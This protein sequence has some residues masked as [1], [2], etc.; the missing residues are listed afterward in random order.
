MS[1]LFL[2]FFRCYFWREKMFFRNVKNC[3]VNMI[4]GK[5]EMFLRGY[6]CNN[7]RDASCRGMTRAVRTRQT[8][9]FFMIRNFPINKEGSGDDP[10]KSY[11][12]MNLPGRRLL[13]NIL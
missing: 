6:Y 3:K 13:L 7:K 10:F 2:Q 8:G 12:R 1:K 11:R 5:A 4:S 9:F